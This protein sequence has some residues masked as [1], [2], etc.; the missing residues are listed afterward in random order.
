MDEFHG[1]AGK[2]PIGRQREHGRGDSFQFLGRGMAGA[3]GPEYRLA[4]FPG[5]HF[6]R[7]DYNLAACYREAHLGGQRS[8]EAIPRPDEK[9]DELPRN[10]LEVF[11]IALSPS[12]CWSQAPQDGLSTSAADGVADGSPV[13]QSTTVL[14]APCICMNGVS[15]RRPPTSRTWV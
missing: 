9:A 6:V 3:N 10:D 12:L 8:L 5:Q 11:G 1:A 14:T 13:S 7:P 15:V 4:V 2:R